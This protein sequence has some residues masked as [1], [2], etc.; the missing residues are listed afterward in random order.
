MGQLKEGAG[1]RSYRRVRGAGEFV[2]KM[3]T[4]RVEDREVGNN[5]R[6]ALPDHGWTGTGDGKKG[7]EELN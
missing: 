3:R 7:K 1:G 4:M 6:G 2:L 5:A